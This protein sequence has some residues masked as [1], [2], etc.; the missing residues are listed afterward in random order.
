MGN[1]IARRLQSRG[2]TVRILDIWEDA[3]RPR[4]IEFVNCDIRDEAGV[5]RAMEGETVTCG[6]GRICPANLA[7][8]G[9][10]A[11]RADA[12]KNQGPRADARRN[13]GKT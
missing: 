9:Y 8:C 10:E 2:E 13:Q 3:S 6:D 5:R 1:L 4:E 11:P 12:R 7:R